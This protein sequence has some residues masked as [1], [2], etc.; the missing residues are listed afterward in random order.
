MAR[1]SELAQQLKGWG[2]QSL[3]KEGIITLSLSRCELE[4]QEDEL[5]RGERRVNDMI[6]QSDN[7]NWAYASK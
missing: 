2:G 3:T 1:D 6:E 7:W 4:D 5:R